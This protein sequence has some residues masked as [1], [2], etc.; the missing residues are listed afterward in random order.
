MSV[1]GAE[2]SR[3]KGIQKVG[4]MNDTYLVSNTQ[5]TL[6]PNDTFPICIIPLIRTGS[7]EPRAGGLV[8]CLNRMFAVPVGGR[9]FY[10]T[11]PIEVKHTIENPEVK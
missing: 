10:Q 2:C 9:G 11:V 4:I 3:A 6:S 7:I 8:H 5:E 1:C